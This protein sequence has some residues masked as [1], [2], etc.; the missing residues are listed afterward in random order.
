MTQ[1]IAFTGAQGTG[2]TTMREALVKHLRAQG[3]IVIDNY[4]GVNESISRDA[5]KQGFSINLEAN[6]ESQYY[7]TA[8]Y[9]SADL[10][11]RK[12]AEIIGADYIVIDRSILDVLPYSKMCERISISHY[13]TIQTLVLGH[14]G[15]Y[16][17]MLMVYC[18]PLDVLVKE[19][20]RSDDREYQKTIDTYIKDNLKYAQD[21]MFMTVLALPAESTNDR[22]VRLLSTLGED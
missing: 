18:G 2:K 12:E 20:D 22:L 7:M 3:K 14:L 17:P 13:Q 11:T 21:K 10:R 6:F 5:K 9:I 19:Q 8:Q 4:V 16:M 1:I 15:H